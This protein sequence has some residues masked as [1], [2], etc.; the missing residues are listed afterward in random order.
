MLMRRNFLGTA[1]AVF[2]GLFT[3]GGA[4]AAQAIRTGQKFSRVDLRI[5]FMTQRDGQPVVR[6]E[7]VAAYDW[8]DD[9]LITFRAISRSTAPKITRDAT[10][11]L[12]PDYRPLEAFTRIQVDGRYEGSG[13][14]RFEENRVRSETYNRTTGNAS[15]ITPI[16]GKVGGFCAHPV[17][18]DVMLI[19]AFD[20]TAKTVR[21][22]L[23]NVFLN[24]PDPFGRTGPELAPAGSVMEYGGRET[25]QTAAGTFETDHYRLF[26]KEADKEPIEYL[27]VLPDTCIFIQAKAGGGFNTTYELAEFR[28]T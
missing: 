10:Y 1:A 16:D 5:R 17:S 8:N 22:K 6:G 19:A 26:S 12:A 25:L 14:F 13:W 20:Q 4:S 27:W 7:E 21:Q 11:T 9:G 18:T 23:R 28:A 24:S 15:R 2:G 3:G